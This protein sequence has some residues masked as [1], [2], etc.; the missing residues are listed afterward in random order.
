MNVLLS[1]SASKGAIFR[2]LASIGLAL[3]LWAWVT[4]LRD[5]ETARTFS[6]VT[7]SPINLSQNLVI[8]NSPSEVQVQVSGPE[9]I[10]DSV[11]ATQVQAIADLEAVDAPGTYSV[12]VNVEVPESV[13]RA[14]AQPS[15]LGITIEEAATREFPLEVIIADL[16][17]SSM[18]SVDV[19][20]A[21]DVVEVRGPTS[22]IDRTRSVAIT[23]ESSGSSRTFE[24][25]FVP[26]ALDESGEPVS[27]VT[28]EPETVD[29]VVTIATRGKSVGVLVATSGS[30]APGFEVLDRTANPTT[31]VVDG[32][33]ALL[34]QL[35]AVTAEFVEISGAT[36]SVSSTVGIADLPEGVRVIQPN[37]G[38][39]DVLVQIGQRGV[40][41]SLPGL[42]VVVVNLSPALSATVSPDVITVEVVAPEEVLGSLTVQSFQVVVD[43]TGLT[44]GVHT[45]Q[46]M[47]IVPSRVQWISATPAQ[48]EITI[49]EAEREEDRS[50]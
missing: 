18:R 37:T 35:I 20:P 13:W 17:A 48:V 49:V 5:P 46:P 32:P 23:L 40:R 42:E 22:A 24:S 15:T 33:E 45:L 4:T 16:D 9:S 43:A 10:I 28:I 31:V 19:A 2:L 39:V 12:P 8:V 6:A 7:V 34:D 30:P 3:L 47:V 26:Q 11:S 29:A 38:Q 1:R 25:T 41:Q 50:S 21:L 14:S 27:G 44:P 36:G